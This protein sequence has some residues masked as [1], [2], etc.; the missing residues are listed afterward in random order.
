MPL[1]ESS[2]KIVVVEDPMVSGLL[3]TVL[4]GNGYQVLPMQAGEGVMLLRAGDSGIGLLITNIPELFKEFGECLPLLYLAAV[5][6]PVAAS[7]FRC[8]RILRKPFH[9]AQLLSCVEQLLPQV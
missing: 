2:D 5:P 3:G 9:P 6:D 1:R 7:C 4:R 8:N